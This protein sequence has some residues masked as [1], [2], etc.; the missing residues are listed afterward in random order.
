MHRDVGAVPG[1]QALIHTS[2]WV[3]ACGLREYGSACRVAYD[4]EWSVVGFWGAWEFMKYACDGDAH[5]PSGY[6]CGQVRGLRSHCP[7]ASLHKD[8][9]CIG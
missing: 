4:F 8:L 2:C 7:H 5:G 3:S 1:P 6:G 9:N